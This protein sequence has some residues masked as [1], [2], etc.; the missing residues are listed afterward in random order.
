MLKSSTIFKLKKDCTHKTNANINLILEFQDRIEEFSRN[1]QSG[2]SVAYLKTRSL[3][4]IDEISSGLSREFSIFLIYENLYFSTAAQF[5]QLFKNYIKLLDSSDYYTSIIL[6]RT[7]L[8]IIAFTSFPLI[9]ASSDHLPKIK[10]VWIELKREGNK[11]PKR[12]QKKTNL[13]KKYHK[14]IDETYRYAIE[15]FYASRLEIPGVNIDA[16]KFRWS[17]TTKPLHINDA[18]REL[19]K[20]SE[21]DLMKTY[22]LL[23]EFCH[24]NYASKKFLTTTNQPLNPILDLVHYDVRP[25]SKDLS[26][27]YLETFSETLL[28]ILQL[29]FVMSHNY[30]KYSEFWGSLFSFV[31]H[32]AFQ[33]YSDRFTKH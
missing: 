26:I 2:F 20:R 28:N 25:K 29:F 16:E 32:T 3:K 1:S 9:K 10:K 24:P 19:T 18:L 8:E 22:D 33:D 27:L 11:V 23:S 21:I 15:T 31:N 13:V 14:L 12:N 7:C 17:E 6:L 4:E 5:N 30:D